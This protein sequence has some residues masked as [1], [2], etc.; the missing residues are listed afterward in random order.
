MVR[1]RREFNIIIAVDTPQTHLLDRAVD[2]EG[3]RGASNPDDYGGLQGLSNS[4][5]TPSDKY[6]RC[7]K[8]FWQ[9]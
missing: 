9:R 2:D 4:P 6:R 8:K 3:V 1:S 5:S 7:G